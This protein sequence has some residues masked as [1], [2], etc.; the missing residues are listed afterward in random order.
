MKGDI[1]GFCRRD[2]VGGDSTG[3]HPSPARPPTASSLL[4]SSDSY[5][6]NGSEMLVLAPLSA[7][8]PLPDVNTDC[9]PWLAVCLRARGA[10]LGRGARLHKCHPDRTQMFSI[11]SVACLVSGIPGFLR[12][13]LE[14]FQHFSRGNRGGEGR[15]NSFMGWD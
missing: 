13:F 7:P 8:Q 12:P 10:V 11:P 1:I 15:G 6:L 3:G 9:F 5:Y 2:G 14:G 4:S